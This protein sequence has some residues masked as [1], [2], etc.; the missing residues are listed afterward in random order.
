MTLN[1]KPIVVI[2]DGWS[3]LGT[4][5]FLVG[6]G[7]QVIWIRGSEARMLSPLGCLEAG[8]GVQV[9]NDLSNLLSIEVGAYEEG[10]FVREFRNKAFRQPP[11]IKAP[12]LELRTQ[13]RD[14]VLWEPERRFV[15]AMDARF[16]LTLNE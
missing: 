11:W 14:E 12:Q 7:A 6:S 9:W 1:S 4:I 10:N 3:A 5:G 2:G 15:G 16:E 8:P 13:V